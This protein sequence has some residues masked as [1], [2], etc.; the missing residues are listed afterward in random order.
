M[1][2]LPPDGQKLNQCSDGRRKKKPMDGTFIMS[3]TEKGVTDTVPM[4]GTTIYHG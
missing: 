1:Q 4:V 2:R 3:S